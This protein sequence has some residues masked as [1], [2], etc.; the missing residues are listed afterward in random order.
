MHFSPEVNAIIASKQL[1]T[2]QINYILHKGDVDFSKSDTR[3]KPCGVYYIKG[4]LNNKG[5]ALTV[6]NCEESA[7]LQHIIF[8]E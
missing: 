2:L 3:K 4:K 7:T 6:E 8:L 5:A 1:D